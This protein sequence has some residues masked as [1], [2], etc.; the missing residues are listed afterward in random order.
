[1]TSEITGVE[2]NWS[3]EKYLLAGSYAGTVIAYDLN[4]QKVSHSFKE[5]MAAV[6][7][8]SSQNK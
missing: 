5:H 7:V 6:G 4:A 3:D 2:F 8:L 1:M